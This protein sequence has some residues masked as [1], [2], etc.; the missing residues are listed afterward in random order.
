[1]IN[2]K[3]ATLLLDVFHGVAPK[4]YNGRRMDVVFRWEGER[5][6]IF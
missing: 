2:I 6:N 3:A 4:A 1:L 5:K